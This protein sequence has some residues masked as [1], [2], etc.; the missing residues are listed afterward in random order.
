MCQLTLICS[1]GPTLTVPR[2]LVADVLKRNSFS[3]NKHGYGVFC[4][5]VITK[6]LDV[7]AT[8]PDF[9][10]KVHSMVT[11]GTVLAHVRQASNKALLGE[12]C[13]HPFETDDL[14]LFHN[15]TLIPKAGEL[16]EN[17]MDT[18]HFVTSLQ[19]QLKDTPSLVEAVKLTVAKYYGKFAFLLYDKRDGMYY[20]IRGK[21]ALLHASRL[22]YKFEDVSY[23]VLFVNTEISEMKLTLHQMGNA[24]QA[25]LGCE[26]SFLE[27]ELLPAETIFSLQISPEGCITL[28][29]EDTVEE[30]PVPVAQSFVTKVTTGGGGPGIDIHRISLALGLDITALDAIC[31]SIFKKPLI[32]LDE[33]D[34]TTLGDFLAYLYDTYFDETHLEEYYALVGRAYNIRSQWDIEYYQQVNGLQFPY[35]F[36]RASTLKSLMP[37]RVK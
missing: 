19:A 15:G 13:L 1:T 5:G 3:T 22:T 10:S 6:G 26:V 20:V 2:L 36:S 7:P 25:A 35:F 34:V 14:I 23:D 28:H 33:V 18:K 27:P 37:R 31:L 9:G 11:H 21:S 8:T 16:K 24:I 12:D 17:E 29:K 30:T 32:E 4:G